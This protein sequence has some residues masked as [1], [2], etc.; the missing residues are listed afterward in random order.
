M[1]EELDYSNT[2]FYKIY[3][4]DDSC[5][6]L[7]VGHT[8]NFVQR[9]NAHKNSSTNTK[10]INYNLKLY[11]TIRKHGGWSNWN[12]V[13]IDFKDCK[14]H[15]DARATEQEYYESLNATLNSVHPLPSKSK[16]QID[17]VNSEICNTYSIESNSSINQ[18][19]N[20]TNEEISYNNI[21]ELSKYT[22]EY[23]QFK[24]ARSYDYNRHLTTAKHKKLSCNI[25]VKHNKKFV[26][27]C[28][29]QYKYRQGLH[30]HKQTCPIQDSLTNYSIQQNPFGSFESFLHREILN[31]NNELKELIKIQTNILCESQRDTYHLQK[32]LLE[33]IHIVKK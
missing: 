16:H 25:Q 22:C 3:C 5:K 31:Q 18:N 7:Y 26:C 24:C 1:K 4:K 11:D 29:K 32:Q 19:K 20:N 8:T 30:Q 21:I 12:M 28:G 6:E 13:I 23:C 2:I 27:V 9:K 17:I 10:S 15:Y 33:H 14:N